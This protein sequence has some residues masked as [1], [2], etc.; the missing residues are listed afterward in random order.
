MW[1]QSRIIIPY[2]S[3][4]PPELDT[5][6]KTQANNVQNALISLAEA[7]ESETE[8]QVERAVG[9]YNSGAA[10]TRALR[11]VFQQESFMLT[12]VNRLMNA[13]DGMYRQPK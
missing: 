8:T 2:T 1:M 4:Q 9:T 13:A 3:G 5:V 11:E 7:V 12:R 10:L 6:S